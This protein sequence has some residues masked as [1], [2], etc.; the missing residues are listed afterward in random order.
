MLEQQGFLVG[1]I[2]PPTVP[3]G[4]ARLRISLTAAHNEA[5]LRQLAELLNQLP[6]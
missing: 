2:R 5:A 1:A 6:R 4:T 3:S